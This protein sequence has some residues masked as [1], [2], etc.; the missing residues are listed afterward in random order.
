MYLEVLKTDRGAVISQKHVRVR[1]C[2]CVHERFASLNKSFTMEDQHY[3][4]LPLPSQLW[5]QRTSCETGTLLSSGNPRLAFLTVNEPVIFDT[6]ERKEKQENHSCQLV[7]VG[8]KA[9][10]CVRFQVQTC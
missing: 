9:M 6:R 7:P 3:N 8:G 1:V 2:V 10:R 5:P 4:G